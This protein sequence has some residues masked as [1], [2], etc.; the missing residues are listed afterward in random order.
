[1]LSLAKLPKKRAK[2]NKY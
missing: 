2:I 1:M